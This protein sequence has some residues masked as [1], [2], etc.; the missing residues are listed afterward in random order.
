M[1]DLPLYL[2]IRNKIMSRIQSG[3]FKSGDRLPTENELRQQYNVSMATVRHALAGL[4]EKRIIRRQPRIGTIVNPQS[5][6][7]ELIKLQ[8]F[9]Q[10]MISKGLK[11]D[12]KVLRLE[13]E[14]TPQRVKDLFC[15]QNISNSWH[16]V[17]LLMANEESIGLQ[18]LYIHPRFQFSPDDII[19]M[20]SFYKLLKDLHNIKPVSS[21]ETISACLAEEQ[22]AEILGISTHDPLLSIWKSVFDETGLAFEVSHIRYVA[23]R[24]EYEVQLSM[25]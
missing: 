9:N 2:Q 18:D 10:M 13:V 22:E 1:S 16:V 20:S 25:S 17:R 6:R 14:K 24:Y 15:D 11:P 23:S 19:G 8:G 7:P 12:V 5:S 3:E 4:E 21:S